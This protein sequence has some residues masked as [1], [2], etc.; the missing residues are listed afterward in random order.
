M[1]MYKME[2]IDKKS[3]LILDFKVDNNDE[4]T[5]WFQSVKHNFIDGTYR[6]HVSDVP[7]EKIKK[8]PKDEP[9]PKKKWWTLGL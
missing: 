6:V 8:A 9:K 3:G 1:T 5:K 4:L 2:I 7:K